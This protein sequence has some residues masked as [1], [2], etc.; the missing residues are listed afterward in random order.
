MSVP[1]PVVK[2]S[3]IRLMTR[4]AMEYGAVNLSQGMTNESPDFDFVWDAACT[5]LGGTEEGKQALNKLTLRDLMEGTG[6]SQEEFLNL[7]LK[8]ALSVCPRPSDAYNQY[9]VPFG[10]AALRN[11]IADNVERFQGFRP[12]PDTEITVACGATEGMFLGLSA[13]CKPGDEVI[14]MQPFHESYLNQCLTLQTTPVYYTL[15]ENRDTESWDFSMSDYEALFT[16]RTKCIILNTPH[17]PT[18]RVFSESELRAIGELCL[19]K[20]VYIVTD[21][22]YEHMIFNPE[23]PHHCIAK[24]KGMRDI[25]LVVNAIS[26]TAKATGWRVG[27]IIA[28]PSLT[29]KIRAIHDSLVLQAPTPLQNAAIS[30]L[31]RDTEWFRAMPKESYDRL[32]IILPAL[33]AAGFQVTMPQGAYYVLADYSKVP[34]LQGKAPMDAAMTLIR[35]CGL[36]PVPGDNFYDPA[37]NVGDSYLRFAVCKTLPVLEQAVAV[38][39]KLQRPE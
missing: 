31:T 26:K 25:S 2:E 5:A 37:S 11:A 4:L 38:L 16:P 9:C 12:D 13:V 15:K 19:R 14:I 8:E 18:G 27:W 32:R 30:V 17:N 33:Q 23:Q 1:Q 21:E 10:T 36:T 20:G 29:K 7:S 35:D 28:C 34:L 39:A 22:I 6:K 24:F 3:V